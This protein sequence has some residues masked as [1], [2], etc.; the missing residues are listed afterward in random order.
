METWAQETKSWK[1]IGADFILTYLPTA[2]K[3]NVS[4]FHGL[5]TCFTRKSV[6][7]LSWKKIS[8]FC[9]TSLILVMRGI[10]WSL[11]AFADMEPVRVFLRTQAVIKF[12]LQLAST[13]E[14]AE[15]K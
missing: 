9:A 3:T 14:N 10:E 4:S 6:D 15:C 2:C 7:F 13:L 1:N 8:Y 11:R 5:E 12:A